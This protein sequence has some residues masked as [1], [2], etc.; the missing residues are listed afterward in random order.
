MFKVLLVFLFSL[1]LF[2]QNS[3]DEIIQNFLEQRKKMMEEMMRAFGDDD[4][5]SDDFNDDKLFES[6]KNHGIGGFGQFKSMGQNVTVE[7]KMQDDG[8]IDVI[9]TP[10]SD[11][12]NLNIETKNNSIIIKSET[13]VAQEDDSESGSSKYFSSSSFSR[14]VSIPDGYQVE[15]PKQK[16]KSII[17]TLR[18]TKDNQ[19]QKSDD[20][21]TPI[22]RRKGEKVI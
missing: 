21:K 18:P 15:D 9:I 2:A 5:F 10:K 14:S 22:K 16:D 1:N 11:N 8:S 7:E 19:L 12:V 6:L 4:F 17:I 20:G 13:K 3:H